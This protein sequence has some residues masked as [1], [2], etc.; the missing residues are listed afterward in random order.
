MKSGLGLAGRLAMGLLLSCLPG[1][2]AAIDD[3]MPDASRPGVE[4]H[5]DAGATDRGANADVTSDLGQAA[6]DADVPWLTGELV[7][8][9]ALLL[10][11]RTGAYRGWERSPHPFRSTAGGGS[12]VF[13]NPI[14]AGS[15]SAAATDHPAG[16]VAL[17]EVY[18]D[19]LMTLRGV[20]VMVKTENRGDS[21]EDWL[22]VELYALEPGGQP[23][24][25]EWGARACLVCHARSPGFVRSTWPL[26]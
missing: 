18:F 1:C 2:W 22:F 17:R 13:V 12:R 14:L 9:E 19:D 24:V 8:T 6:V 23:T 3:E 26:D 10:W 21:A 7:D 16:A 20:N 15:L 4:S 25:Y 11:A 5:G